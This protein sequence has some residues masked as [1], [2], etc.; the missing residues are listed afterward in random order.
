MKF[1]RIHINDRKILKC[2]KKADFSNKSNVE[3]QMKIRKR[4]DSKYLGEFKRVI[5]QHINSNIK[6]YLTLSI[7]FIIGV[8]AGVVLINNSDEKSKNEISGYINGFIDTIKD[9]KYEVDKVKLTKI[10]IMENL[11]IVLII[12]IAGSTIIGIPLIYIIISYK[13][14]CIGYTISAIISSL[15]IWRRNAVFTGVLVPSKHYCNSNNFD[16]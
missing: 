4:Y 16:A 2:L 7:I 10:S 3:V 13:G 8:M 11:K 5:I 9:E 15:G 12:W 1:C 6:D 14:F